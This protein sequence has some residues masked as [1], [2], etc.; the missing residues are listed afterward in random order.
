MV[1]WKGV[2][3]TLAPGGTWEEADG[4]ETRVGQDYWYGRG[5]D[6]FV[7]VNVDQDHVE[8]SRPAK[9]DDEGEPGILWRGSIDDLAVHPE[10]G[11]F[12]TTEAA[13]HP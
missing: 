13:A 10:L 2:I 1:D 5:T 8:I 12:A 4:P 3:E 11:R 6:E 9:D 7:R